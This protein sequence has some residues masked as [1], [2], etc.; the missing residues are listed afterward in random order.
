MSPGMDLLA[1]DCLFWRTA[2]DLA[3][4]RS[5]GVCLFWSSFDLYPASAGELW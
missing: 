5:W 2:N 1:G 3:K 4:R